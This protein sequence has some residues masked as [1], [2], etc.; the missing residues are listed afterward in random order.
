MLVT[1][2]RAFSSNS[3]PSTH[4][5]MGFA[6][7]RMTCTINLLFLLPLLSRYSEARAERI[8]RAAP[9]GEDDLVRTPHKAARTFARRSCGN[10]SPKHSWHSFPKKLKGPCNLHGPFG[11]NVMQKDARSCDAAKNNDVGAGKLA[12]RVARRRFC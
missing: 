5:L 6:S 11:K 4:A 1:C 12:Q 9:A 7:V 3:T 8:A 2:L 10:A